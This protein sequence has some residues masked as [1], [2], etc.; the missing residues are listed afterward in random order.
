MTLGTWT[1]FINCMTNTNRVGWG[2]RDSVWVRLGLEVGYGLGGIKSG[3][4]GTGLICRM[5]AWVQA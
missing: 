1:P 2:R 4:Q 3:G 5:C